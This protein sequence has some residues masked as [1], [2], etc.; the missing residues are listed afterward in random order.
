M[1]KYIAA[2]FFFIIGSVELVLALNGN[3]REMV[4][5]NSFI[6]SKRAERPL[7]F[8]AGVSAIAIGIGILFYNRFW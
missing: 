2:I 3:L 8:L 4:M 1:W 6:R 5:K 7:L